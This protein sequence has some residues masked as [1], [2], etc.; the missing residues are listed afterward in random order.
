MLS[1][2][3]AIGTIALLLT[4]CTTAP[5][6]IAFEPGM[7]QTLTEVKVLSI[8]PQDEIVVRA[9]PVGVAPAM[10]GGL[11]GAMIDSKV[12]ESRQNTLQETL[13]PFY[14]AI[15]DYDFRTHFEHTLGSTLA[16][17]PLVKFSPLERSTLP[18]LPKDATARIAKLQAKS[19]Q[20]MVNTTYTFTTDFTRLNVTS[21]VE[22]KVPGT[23][24][25]VF[26]NTY[27]Y[28]SRPI[29]TGGPDSIKHWSNT[30]GTVYRTT[31]DEAAQEMSR[32]LQADLAA[33]ATDFPGSASVSI[34]KVDGSRKQIIS[35]PVL[36]SSAS[37][38]II[39]HS[40]GQIYSL[41]L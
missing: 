27:F 12:G 22:I 13:A 9:D 4:A 19:G 3:I 38:K 28:Q 34:E 36:A 26:M 1:R 16:A 31:L 39:R 20:M 23:E 25:P 21:Y 5:T 33:G 29:G 10:G 18:M 37:R 41:P 15:D 24:A 14:A 11:I 32:M 40:T 35:G 8:L 17:N 6:R 7:R 2:M 30:K